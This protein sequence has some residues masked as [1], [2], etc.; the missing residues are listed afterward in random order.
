MKEEILGS[1][2]I[3]YMIK[4]EYAVILSCSGTSGY[5]KIPE[6]IEGI[7]VKEIGAYSFSSPE[8]GIS[9]LKD[10]T[11]IREYFFKGIDTPFSSMELISGKKLKDVFLPEGITRIGEYAFYNCTELES[12][13]LGEGT[14]EFGNGAFMNCD[15]LRRLRFRTDAT[16]FTGLAGFLREIQGEL[17]VIFEKD[18]TRA[19]FI[20][21]EYYEESIENTP[22]RLFHYLIHGAGYRYR[23]CL[24][25]GILEIPMYDALFLTPEIQTEEDTALRI[26]LSRLRHPYMLSEVHK[27]QYIHYLKLHKEETVKLYILKNDAKGLLT[28]RQED[29]LTP[30]LMDY[31]LKESI[32]RKQ[33]ECIGVLMSMQGEKTEK[34]DNKFEL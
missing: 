34:D 26:A 7:P 12:I 1:L 18:G 16:S 33:P 4:D 8:E 23:Q 6:K 24:K 19:E 3:K 14:I 29:I 30:A 5:I 25:K 11:E 15:S 21:P 13:G 20:F 9:P 2:A 28:L 31:A 22:A 32:L 10:L 27:M 17:T